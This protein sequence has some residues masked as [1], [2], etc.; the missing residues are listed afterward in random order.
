MDKLLN[1]LASAALIAAC[2]VF[3]IQSTRSNTS[4]AS[5]PSIDL[6]NVGDHLVELPVTIA[7]QAERTVFLYVNSRCRFCTNSMPLYRDLRA[8]SAQAARTRFVVASSEPEPMLAAYLDEHGLTANDVVTVQ[9]ITGGK[10]RGTPT[11][12]IVDA[13]GRITGIW[14][15]EQPPTKYEEILSAFSN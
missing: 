15:G 13:N 5:R 9:R 8:R 12:V 11:L 1:N 14:H 4:E 2:V 7:A 6:Y 10:L 3:V